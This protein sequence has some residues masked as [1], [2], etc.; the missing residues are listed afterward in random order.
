MYCKNCGNFIGSSGKMCTV[1][2]Q[3]SQRG[4]NYCGV[5]GKGMAINTIYCTKCGCNNV[6]SSNE[7]TIKSFFKSLSSENGHSKKNTLIIGVV[8]GFTG[9]HNFYLGYNLKGLIQLL[10]FIFSFGFFSY[11]WSVVEMVMILTGRITKAANGSI[12]TE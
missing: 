11:I 8:A 4:N 7:S 9:L 6:K 12:L 2:K 5:C 1:C 10:L 3:D